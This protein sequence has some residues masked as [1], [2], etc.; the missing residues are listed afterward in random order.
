[1]EATIA[2]NRNDRQN[3]PSFECSLVPHST[4]SMNLFW[5]AATWR[6][7]FLAPARRRYISSLVKP[8]APP[9]RRAQSCGKPQHSMNQPRLEFRL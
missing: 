4:L 7:F 1:M 2:T 8:N 3:L 6:R 9:G 5:S